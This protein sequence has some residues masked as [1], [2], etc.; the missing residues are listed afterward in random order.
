[1]T[2]VT[3]L[4]ASVLATARGEDADVKSLAAANRAFA[5][6]LHQQLVLAGTGNL[7]YS[8]YSISTALAMTYAGSR[9]DTEA[10]LANA[11]HFPLAAA[12]IAPA[13]GELQR[14]I[15]AA[16]G[17]GL[18]LWVANSLWPSD[19]FTF[20]SDYIDLIVSRFESELHPVDY[21]HADAVRVRINGWIE[22]ATREKIR[23]MI[24]PGALSALT[25]MVLVNAVYFKGD[26]ATMFSAEATSEQPF[27]LNK[28]ET[29]PVPLMHKQLKA[30]YAETGDAQILD[31]P[32]AGDRISMTVVLP[33]P[34]RS[35]VDIERTLTE[36][37]LAGWLAL[38][39]REVDVFLPKFS[40]TSDFSLSQILRA[41]G[42][43]H[44]FD[45]GAADFSG[46][47]GEAGD[48]YI[49]EVLHKAFVEVSEEGTEAAAATAVIMRTTAFREPEPVPVF[50]ADRP[51]L[52]FIKDRAT[53]SILFTGRFAK[54][55]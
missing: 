43:H 54:P 49:D 19:A 51:F 47:G 7:F 37:R 31:L 35:L 55:Q 26:W 29:I 33:G 32:Y 28:I 21:N 34:E 45:P 40:M 42:A 12:K 14:S 27:F 3:V 53:G 20:S 30:G 36:E 10:Q 11:L 25:R 46:M 17:E 4:F 16:Q 39:V 22:Q 1:M 52:F 2:L 6:A 50:R 18:A 15:R 23:D 38:P 44:P 13:F 5:V 24:P 8:P 41:M 9:G 48:L